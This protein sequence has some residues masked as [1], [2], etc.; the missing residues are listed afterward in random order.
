MNTLLEVLLIN[1]GS[2]TLLIVPALVLSRFV[3]RPAL[4]HTLWALVLIKLLTPPVVEVAALPQLQPGLAAASMAYELTGAQLPGGGLPATPVSGARA[5][6]ARATPVRTTDLLVA[7]WL[8]GSILV[9]L[10][11]L[12]RAARFRRLVAK[13]QPAPAEVQE[14]AELLA[15]RLGLRD[16][17]PLRIVPGRLPPML[18]WRLGRC[19]ILLPSEL[20]GRLEAAELNALLAHELAHVRRRDHW[21]RLVET[22]ACVL[23]WWYPAVWWIR[24]RLRAAEERACDVEVLRVNPGRARAYAEGLLKTLDFLSSRGGAIPALATGASETRQIK[25]RLTM[26]MKREIPQRLTRLQRWSLALVALPALL[27]FPTWSQD[28][29]DGAKS[30]EKEL[31]ASAERHREEMIELRERAIELE[32]QMREKESQRIELEAAMEDERRRHESQRMQQRAVE[33]QREGMEERAEELR[34]H[35]AELEQV[36]E[37]EAAHRAAELDYHERAAELEF[38]MQRMALEHERRRTAGDTAG[39]RELEARIA[40]LELELHRTA[41]DTDRGLETRRRGILSDLI[42]E[43]QHEIERL[44]AQGRDEEAREL[45]LEIARMRLEL[46]ARAHLQQSRTALSEMQQK[47][48]SLRVLRER[49]AQHGDPARLEQLDQEIETLGVK[50]KAIELQRTAELHAQEMAMREAEL[51]ALRETLQ[52]EQRAEEPLD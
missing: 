38:E 19:E 30:P 5:M 36:R 28:D 16:C 12:V 25:E 37:V 46:D 26:I 50:M 7:V 41:R 43:R 34:R 22:G 1:A 42:A 35:S 52:R 6:P 47:L 44:R 9:T 13:V 11:V 24:R 49:Q 45:E 31:V 3:R 32:L 23:F 33:L 8:T 14:R 17:P 21:M 2:A 4:I 20:L 40:D 48:E 39:A 10:L 15:W 27:V 51:Q 18:W 29:G